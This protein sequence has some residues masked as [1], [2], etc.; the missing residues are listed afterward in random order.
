MRRDERTYA[1]IGAAMEVHRQLGPGYLESIY[2]QALA[3]EFGVGGIGFLQELLL[4]V[5]YK[6]HDLGTFR[7]DFLCHGTI[8][9]EIK[10]TGS[11]SRADEAQIIHYLASSARNIGLLINFGSASLEYR[12]MISPRPGAS[13]PT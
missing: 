13:T 4:P 8:I 2:R 12:R 6:G 1:I 9:V 11:L 10:A 3:I 5:T 7:A